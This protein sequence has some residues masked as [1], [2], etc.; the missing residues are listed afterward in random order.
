MAPMTRCCLVGGAVGVACGPLP[1]VLTGA[2][3]WGPSDFGS[4][5]LCGLGE[6]GA[7]HL[8]L[9]CPAG[10]LAWCALAPGCGRL[11][12]KVLA[13]AEGPVDAAAML[14]HLASFFAFLAAKEGDDAVGRWLVRACG[15]RGYCAWAALDGDAGE[16]DADDLDA[17]A[18]DGPPPGLSVLGARC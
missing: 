3:H 14:I 16:G 6:G 2:W 15:P 10:A 18:L 12:A 4:C 5:P 17:Q 13:G 11:L 7:E 1:D 9:W 8:M